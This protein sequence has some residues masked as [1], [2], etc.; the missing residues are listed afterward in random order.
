MG[1]V[2]KA[3]KEYKRYMSLNGA[4]SNG[5]YNL[6]CAY[7]L[8]NKFQEAAAAFQDAVRIDPQFTFAFN[9]LGWCFWQLGKYGEAVEAFESAIRINPKF[10]DALFNLGASYEI[11][12]RLDDA[13]RSF[14]AALDIDP[15]HYESR[16]QLREIDKF[17]QQKQAETTSP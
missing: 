8:Q 13:K 9:N 1:L 6:G 14:Q 11:V 2:E 4:S 15:Q 5:S 17:L 12:G 16:D 10:I 7:V 3:V